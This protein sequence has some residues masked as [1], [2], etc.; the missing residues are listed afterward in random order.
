MV[1]CIRTSPHNLLALSGLLARKFIGRICGCP[2]IN[3]S[4]KAMS[5]IEKTFNYHYYMQMLIILSGH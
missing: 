1:G 5:S 4:Y 3:I 2:I